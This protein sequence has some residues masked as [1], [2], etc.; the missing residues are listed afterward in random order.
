MYNMNDLYKKYYDMYDLATKFY[1]N[2]INTHEG[3][4]AKEYLKNRQINEEIIK[5][6]QVGFSLDKKKFIN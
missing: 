3:K 5:R 1:Q 4:E 2:N 6:F